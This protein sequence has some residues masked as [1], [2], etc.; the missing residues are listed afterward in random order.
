MFHEQL[1][2][3]ECA[4]KYFK[5]LIQEYEFKLIN[6]SLF[7]IEFKKGNVLIQLYHERISYEFYLVIT[8]KNHHAYLNQIFEYYNKQTRAY[9]GSTLENVEFCTRSLAE[10]LNIFMKEIYIR[11]EKELIQIL[12][13]C[14]PPQ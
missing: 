4:N 5:F 6:N 1:N 11:G 12:N 2:F 9:Q 3:I 10:E 14:N 13:K 8:I 7:L